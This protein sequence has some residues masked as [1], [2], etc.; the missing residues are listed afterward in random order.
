VSSRP[1][2]SSP[3]PTSSGLAGA[4]AADD[5]PLK[6]VIAE[7]R[8]RAQS[9]TCVCGWEGSTETTDGRTS[10]WSRHVAANRTSR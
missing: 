6:H 8:H 10:P 1:I 2:G 3:R 9:V 5:V 4:S 7:Y